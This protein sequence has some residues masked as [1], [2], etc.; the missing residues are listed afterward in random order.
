MKKI[1]AIALVIVMMAAIS[2]PAFAADF[3]GNAD[4]AVGGSTTVRYGVDQTYTVS[5]PETITLNT[6]VGDT[7]KKS[8][9]GDITV[10]DVC[11]PANRTLRLTVN[12]SI[13]PSGNWVLTEVAEEDQSLTGAADVQY[14]ISGVQKKQETV[15]ATYDSIV[16]N[17]TVLSV[18][19]A[20]AFEAE[21]TT[22]TFIANKTMQVAKY[23]DN[24]TFTVTII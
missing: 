22:L 12:S 9:T 23:E 20:I 18:A 6:P 15:T 13:T 1:F 2:I 5:I 19:S 8:G 21:T 3:V 10:S 16:K 14:V 4:G 24:L 7:G 17:G 11:I